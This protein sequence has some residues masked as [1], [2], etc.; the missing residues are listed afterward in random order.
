MPVPDSIKSLFSTLLVPPALLYGL[1]MRLARRLATPCDPGI[2]CV[3]VGGM[4]P[5][6]PGTVLVTSWLLGWADH[7]GLR[8]AV[9]APP[10]RKGG[11]TQTLRATPGADPGLIDAQAI[12]LSMY[13]PRA[14]VLCDPDPRRAVESAIGAFRPDLLVAHDGLSLPHPA[15]GLQIVVLGQDDLT[16]GFNRPI[17]AGRWR[18]DASALRR[19]DMFVVYM[20]PGRF[21]EQAGLMEKRLS[22]YGRPVVGV[23]PRAWRLRQVAGRQTAQDFAGEPYLLLT[24]ESERRTTPEALAA[25]L[26]APR[27]SVIFPDGH[28]FTVQELR[29]VLH[30]ATRLKCPRVV[31]PPV[32]AIR[33]A[34]RL[35]ALD[36]GDAVALWTYDPDVV[37][38]A[39]LPQGE[40]FRDW[41]QAAWERITG[42]TTA[43]TP[44]AAPPAAPADAPAAEGDLADDAPAEKTRPRKKTN[45]PEAQ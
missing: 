12:A 42:R 1:G 26:P 41:W 7:H 45:A 13:A 5:G 28:R 40:S 21:A 38:G 31:C 30:D 43:D 35:A 24:T 19:A 3:G 23:S 44:R 20:P 4:Q 6:L 37:F 36:G 22:R 10:W 18:E 29:Q 11:E 14:A 39:S 16:T 34:A 2:P 8:T 32:T 9:I 33:L 15:R 27:L 25:L 17:P